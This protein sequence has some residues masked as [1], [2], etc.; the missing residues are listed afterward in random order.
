MTRKR[1]GRQLRRRVSNDAA[2]RQFLV[3]VEGTVTEPRYIT[4]WHRRHRENAIVTI[5]PV[6]TAPLQ[7]VH[8]AVEAKRVDAR[9]ARRD[10]GRPYDEIWCVFDVD[11]HPDLRTAEDLARRHGI[12][13]AVSNP[14]IE[15]WFVLHF[16]EQTGHIDRAA[17]QALSAELLG[18][19]K[20]LTD[21]ALAALWEQTSAA[22]DRAHRLDVK[23]KGDGS[24]HGS[25]PSSGLWKL[26]DAL[27]EPRD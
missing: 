27:A 22:R 20:T 17:A 15:L 8:R 18:C 16:R 25:N 11:A 5:E 3:F 26:L 24:P 21:E 23:H 12:N 1:A 19:G 6:A 13:L 2:R 9:Q 14:C 7:S 10:K 4:D